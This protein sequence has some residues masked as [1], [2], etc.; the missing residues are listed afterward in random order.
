MYHV[1]KTKFENFDPGNE[2]LLSEG[3]CRE[4]EEDPGQSLANHSLNYAYNPKFV[5]LTQLPHRTSNREGST[6]ARRKW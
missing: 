1:L 4:E 5:R 3:V 6:L 2:N